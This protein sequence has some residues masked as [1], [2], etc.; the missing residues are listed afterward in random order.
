MS[1]QKIS[2]REFLQKGAALTGASAVL[3]ACGPGMVPAPTTAPVPKGEEEPAPTTVPTAAEE[4]IT[5]NYYDVFSMGGET[6]ILEMIAEFEEQNPNI[7]INR[8]QVPPAPS[9]TWAALNTALASDDPPDLFFASG[10]GN[11][12]KLGREG[13]IVDVTE[14]VKSWG[15]IFLPG[16]V[17]QMTYKGTTY[18]GPFWTQFKFMTYN[19][20]IYDEAGLEI[21]T[22]W[23]DFLS[24]GVEL[25]EKKITPSAFGALG[26][27]Q[28]A[29]LNWIALFNQKLV[30]SDTVVRD[31]EVDEGTWD[32]PGYEKALELLAYLNDESYF[33]VNPVSRP[34]QVAQAK[35]FA[36]EAAGMYAGSWDI[37]T[38]LDPS[39]APEGFMENCVFE[40]QIWHDPEWPGEEFNVQGGAMG[41]SIASNAKHPKE[42]ALLMKYLC[43]A[44]GA[45]KY[46][47]H[48][49][50]IMAA[51]DVKPQF[52]YPQVE[53]MV[54]K[55]KGA[56]GMFDFLDQ[57]GDPRVWRV[58]ATSIEGVLNH[59][60]TPAEAMAQVREVAEEAKKG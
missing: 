9:E 55:L 13:T 5:L 14:E 52:D 15:D 16:M 35:L 21:P 49:K 44:E 32:D 48:T 30:G 1:A 40:P 4:A 60:I 50:Y 8:V 33:G 20:T 38:M 47:N 51:K 25:M 57:S 45:Q 19:K 34:H 43:G 17:E 3:V 37:A 53:D 36:S 58:Y 41:F 29:S 42:A 12:V 31:M 2:R 56:G 22:T 46:H 6:A 23:K 39:K 10:R 24:T 26:G 7:K 27:D 18:A 28:W 54:E 59:E 11:I